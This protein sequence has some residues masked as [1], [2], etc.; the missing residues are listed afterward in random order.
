VVVFL[1]E[2]VSFLGT[3]EISNVLLSPKERMT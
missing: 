3:V 1:D 2:H